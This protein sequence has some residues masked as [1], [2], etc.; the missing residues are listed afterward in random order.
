[1]IDDRQKAREGAGFQRVLVVASLGLAVLVGALAWQNR[2]LKRQLAEVR[3]PVASLAPGERLGPIELLDGQGSGKPLTFAGDADHTLLLFFTPTCPACRN[4]VPVW[5]QLVAS[6]DSRPRIL[7]IDLAPPGTPGA[8][9]ELGSEAWPFPVF[10]VDPAHSAG[11][12][13]IPY[14]PATVIVD[15][16][17]VVQ[18]VWFGEL[19]ARGQRELVESLAAG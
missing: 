5:H 6:L 3:A 4:T 11:L 9:Q 8:S 12:S 13:R 17:G 19:D 7:G 18:R 15:G 2:T 10:R 1:M 14:V 16:D